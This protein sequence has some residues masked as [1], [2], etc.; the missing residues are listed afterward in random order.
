VSFTSTTDENPECPNTYLW[1]RRTGSG[2]WSNV[3]TGPNLAG[4]SF[5][6]APGGG[7]TN[8]D[9]RLTVTNSLG[10]DSETVTV[11]VAA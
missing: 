11:R 8:Y 6:D 9:I 10:S 3:G 5:T 4:Q 7:A 2:A 1:E